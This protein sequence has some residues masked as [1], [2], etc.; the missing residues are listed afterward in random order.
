MKQ[1]EALTAWGKGN[2]ICD[3][4]YVEKNYYTLFLLKFLETV[5]SAN[6]KQRE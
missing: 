6:G 4:N 1:V 5:L 2:F 3:N